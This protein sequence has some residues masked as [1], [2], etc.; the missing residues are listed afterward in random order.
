M[1]CD[2]GARG[3]LLSD[4]PREH[5]PASSAVSCCAAI[6]HVYR[7]NNNLLAIVLGLLLA[8]CCKVLRYIRMYGYCFVF[9]R[10]GW[11]QRTPA[12]KKTGVMMVKSVH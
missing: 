3:G 6:Y 1:F 12:Q 7:I 4:A 11:V 10:R 5:K 2:A 8:R 9:Q